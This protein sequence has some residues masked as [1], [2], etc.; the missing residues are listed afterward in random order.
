MIAPDIVKFEVSRTAKDLESII[1]RQSNDEKKLKARMFKRGYVPV[2]DIP[3]FMI[4][5]FNQ[6]NGTFDYTLIMYGARCDENIEEYEGWL[7]GEWI[8][9]SIKTKS[10]R[11]LSH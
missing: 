1:S 10:D 4:H 11:L 5:S 8:K 7:T 6:D 3:P 2:L 9:S